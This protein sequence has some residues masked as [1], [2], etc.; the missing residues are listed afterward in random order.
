MQLNAEN[1]PFPTRLAPAIWAILV[2]IR[3]LQ[4]VKKPICGHVKKSAVERG[5]FG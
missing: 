5:A 2:V 4:D 3:P 1:D